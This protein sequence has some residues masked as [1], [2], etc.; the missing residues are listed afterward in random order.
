LLIVSA[1][2]ERL[3]K[4][5]TNVEFK[6]S[7]DVYLTGETFIS[8]KNGSGIFVRENGKTK[9]IPRAEWDEK[10]PNREPVI[11]IVRQQEDNT[12]YHDNITHNLNEMA[13]K[14]GIY[15]DLWYPDEIGIVQARD[16][17]EPLE[18]GLAF[19]ES[20]PVYFK[21]FNPTNGWGDY[22]GLVEFVCNYLAACKKYPEAKIEVSR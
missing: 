15:R 22:E 2:A 21:Q 14:A 1:N 8:T 18:S 7:L 19:L 9:E 3:V 6:M 13:E 12:V 4:N 17:I 10:F 11:V 20:K 5:E 16:L